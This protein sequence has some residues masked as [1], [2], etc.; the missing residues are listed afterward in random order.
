MEIILTHIAFICAHT[1]RIYNKTI[2]IHTQE[3]VHT[4]EL[5]LDTN[6]DGY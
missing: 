5:Q 4:T 1:H 3:Q 2:Q 6:D